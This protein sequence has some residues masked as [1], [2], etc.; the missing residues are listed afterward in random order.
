MSPVSLAFIHVATKSR[1][2]R[3]S[4]VMAPLSNISF[5]REEVIA[6]SSSNCERSTLALDEAQ[7][8]IRVDFALL[9]Y[10]RFGPKADMCSAKPSQASNQP[11]VNTNRVPT[12][13]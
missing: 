4:S 11:P 12:A 3:S 7:G 6:I 9:G 10:V 5:A 2:A 1:I 8:P 13:E